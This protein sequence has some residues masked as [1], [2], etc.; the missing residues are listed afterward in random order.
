MT[1]GEGVLPKS[2]CVRE[3][4][5]GSWGPDSEG[6]NKLF[7]FLV[8]SSFKGLQLPMGAAALEPARPGCRRATAAGDFVGKRFNLKPF[9][10][11]ADYTA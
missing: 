9:V 10:H 3:S 2:A 11:E 1:D 8:T 5:F 6:A 4:G 7:G